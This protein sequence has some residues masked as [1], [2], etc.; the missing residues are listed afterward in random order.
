VRRLLLPLFALASGAFALAPPS[1][2]AACLAPTITVQPTSGALGSGFAIHGEDFG[3]DCNDVNPQPGEPPLGEPAQSILLTLVDAAGAEHALAT[4]DAADDYTFDVD[5][6]VP[7]AAAGAGRVEAM[8]HDGFGATAPFAVLGE[9]LADCSGPTV[10]V[11]PRSGAPGS[12]VTITGEAFGDACNDV[13]PQPGEPPLGNPLQD[14]EVA[15]TDAGHA[16]FVLGVVDAGPQYHWTLE[17]S[18]P[19]DAAL[20]TGSFGANIDIDVFVG[21]A[22]FEVVGEPTVIPAEPAFT[23]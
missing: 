7:D 6:E 2:E 1:V 11:E 18:V 10:H 4:V 16:T 12:A 21:S 3:T 14:I 13:N 15:F 9:G 19:G 8:V 23:G 20:G 5:A 17:S 22:T